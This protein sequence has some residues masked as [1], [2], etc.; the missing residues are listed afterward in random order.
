MLES[1][2]LQSYDGLFKIWPE[3]I[4]KTSIGLQALKLNLNSLNETCISSKSIMQI[5]KN[6]KNFADTAIFIEKK[7]GKRSVV[8]K[9]NASC[10]SNQMMK[11]DEASV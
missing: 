10:G 8:G 5:N 11:N 2:C 1:E 9:K 6:K 3:N 4:K 7:E